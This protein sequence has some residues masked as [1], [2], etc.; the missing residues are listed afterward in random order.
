M[1]V[2]PE[3]VRASSGD[4]WL[5]GV[6]LGRALTLNETLPGSSRAA[7]WRPIHERIL[8]PSN[9]SAKL[10]SM[11]A[12]QILSA[13][14]RA[15]VHG[16]LADVSRLRIVDTLLLGDA[17]PSEL[18]V[19]LQMPSNLLAHHLRAL[20]SAGLVK[21]RRSEGDRR[22]S[23]L[24]LHHEALEAIQLTSDD[25]PARVL[26]VCTA[27]SARSQLASALWRQVSRIPATSAG[28]R[29]A[30]TID[31]GAIAV[32]GRHELP[33]PRLRPRHLADVLMP[34]D[35]VITV[36]DLAH[37]ELGSAGRLHW[38][39]PDPVRQGQP[40]AFDG[41]FAELTERVSQLA[42]CLPQHA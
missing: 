18:A 42:Q 14:R 22:R 27:N 6:R 20:E 4:R 41:V 7:R 23:Y 38:S 2:S 1:T 30:D 12:E 35:L 36:C 8:T 33:L 37:E 3:S 28:T 9:T 21:R 26:F 16:A 29:P 11:D 31:P 15:A 25:R 19:M 17:S 32:A 34:D 5:G 24:H 40:S 39:V 13:K 10:E